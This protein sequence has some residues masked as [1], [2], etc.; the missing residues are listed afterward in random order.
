MM[1][2]G[3]LMPFGAHSGLALN[4]GYNAHRS[5][6]GNRSGYRGY[7]YRNSS[8]VSSRMRRLSKLVRDLNTLTVGSTPPLND[9]NILR[10]DLM[11]LAQGGMRPPSTSVNQLSQHLVNYLPQRST[12]LLNTERLA[13]NLETVMNGGR[14]N[15]GQ[16]NRAISS[17]QSILRSSGLPQPGLQALNT[18]MRSVG[19]WG[20]MAGNQAGIIR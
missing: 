20:G 13:L 3:A 8:M 12:P 6:Y 19:F 7:G 15:S 17:S 2:Y 5:Y 18:A 11:A 4:Q 16:V 1:M 9:R 14:L 10:N